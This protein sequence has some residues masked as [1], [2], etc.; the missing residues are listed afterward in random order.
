MDVGDHPRRSEQMRSAHETRHPQ[1]KSRLRSR[2]FRLIGGALNRRIHRN[3]PLQS[4]IVRGMN[5]GM[6]GYPQT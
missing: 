4:Y 1:A 3:P 6:G 2:S 5:S